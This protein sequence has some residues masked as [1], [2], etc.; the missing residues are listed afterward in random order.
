MS[1]L[2]KR[3]WCKLDTLLKESKLQPFGKGTEAVLYRL[4]EVLPLLRDSKSLKSPNDPRDLL[5]RI[6]DKFSPQEAKLYAALSE[7]HIV[8]R[9]YESF[10]LSCPMSAE[11]KKYIQLL[12]RIPGET[13]ATFL[14]SKMNPTI[15]KTLCPRLVDKIRQMH[16]LNILHRDL[17][18]KNIMIDQKTH[19]PWIIDLGQAENL[20]GQAPEDIMYG[21]RNDILFL[22][23]ELEPYCE[24]EF[25]KY[26]EELAQQNEKNEDE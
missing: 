24:E 7:K 8:P 1:Q 11:K 15:A 2:S 22:R 18:L 19:E 13:L 12:Q 4:D 20:S 17:D 5:V 25:T 6:S 10:P 14:P 3:D 9:L 26:R 21:K 23:N 16:A